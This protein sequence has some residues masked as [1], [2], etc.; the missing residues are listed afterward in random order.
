[1]TAGVTADVRAALLRKYRLLARWRWAK[2]AEAGGAGEA[3]GGATAGEMR[4][5]AEEFPGALR[6]L[7]LL[8]LAELERRAA[9]LATAPEYE[10]A[11]EHASWIAWISAYHALLRLALALR[12]PTPPAT[13]PSSPAD[14]MFLSDVS[15]PPGGRLSGVVLQA[16]GRHFGLPAEEIRA[17]L[18]PP[19][20]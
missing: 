20:R 6:E 19:R 4:A 16:L 3:T 10:P 15:R 9:H 2:D 7:D 17:V 5:L 18:F 11:N 13:T 8:G 14:E 12:G 1:M